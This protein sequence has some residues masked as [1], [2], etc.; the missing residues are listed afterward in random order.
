MIKNVKIRLTS[1]ALAMSLATAGFVAVP[2]TVYATTKDIK[3]EVN[4]ETG[5]EQLR[6]DVQKGDTVSQIS[7]Y[8]VNR[9]KRNGEIPKEDL[10]I[11]E[12]DPDTK[13]R[14]WPGIVYYYVLTRNEELAEQGKKTRVKR[15]RLR[16]DG[17]DIPVPGSYEELKFYTVMAKKTGFHAAY[18]Q[19]NN[20]YVKPK[21]IYVDKNE[22]IRRIQEVFRILSPDRVIEIDDNMLHTYL[23]MIGGSD[24][25][26][27][28]KNGAKLK[29]DDLW[30]F[31]ELALYPEEVEAEMAKPKR[32]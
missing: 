2:K 27:V 26:F 22:A 21:I 11:F 8:L 24:S 23:R 29:G 12:S 19:A 18:C 3:V 17:E 14:F 28:I 32:K 6:Y 1:A 9:F 5:E 10:E 30:R 15:L 20:I 31:N 7:V 25:K 16:P 13:C 4:E